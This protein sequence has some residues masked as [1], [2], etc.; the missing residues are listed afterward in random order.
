MKFN[1]TCDYCGGSIVFGRPEERPATCPSCNSY[2]G[3][4]TA[5]EIPGEAMP[6]PREDRQP[7]GHLELVCQKSGAII[8]IDPADRIEI[9]RE[10]VGREV[11]SKTPQISRTHCLIECEDGKFFLTDLD[12]RNGTFLGVSRIDCRTNPRQLVVDGELVYLGRE[13]FLFR[14]VPRAVSATANEAVRE[15]SDRKAV[16]YKCPSCGTEF[17]KD[18]EVCPQCGSYGPLHPVF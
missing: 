18:A 7:A 8:R 10:A 3:H 16:R 5:A 17:E 2:L 11:L 14:V 12:S 1:L 9:G 15:S 4:L 6:S 13:P